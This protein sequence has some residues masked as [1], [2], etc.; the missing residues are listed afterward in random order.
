M[1]AQPVLLPRPGRG[2]A[3]GRTISTAC[4]RPAPRSARSSRSSA[5][6]VPPGLGAPVYGK[7]DARPRRGADEHQCGQ[8]RRDRR[9]V[10]RRRALRGEENADE[11]RMQDGRVVFGVEPC[12]RHPRRHLHRPAD[13]RAL[14]R[15]ADQLDPDAAPFGG[16]RRRRGRGQRPRAGTTPAS[17]SGPCRSARRCWPACWPTICCATGRRIRTRPAR[18]GCRA[19]DLL[20]SR[21]E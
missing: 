4:A 18:P 8:G 2:G 12:R 14:R 3:S 15:Q 5:D 11:M 17:A 19:T 21:R 6:G 9:R 13:R 1:D 20:A 10:R 16:P 7:L